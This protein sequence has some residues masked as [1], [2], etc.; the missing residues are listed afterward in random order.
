[1]TGYLYV[2]AYTTEGSIKQRIDR[3]HETR[4]LAECVEKLD[5]APDV[6]ECDTAICRSKPFDKA[7]RVVDSS[8]KS[9]AF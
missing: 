1:M 3:M 9:D 5:S 6:S 4:C 2:L 7:R 8:N